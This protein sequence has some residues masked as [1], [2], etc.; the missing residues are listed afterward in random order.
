MAKVMLSLHHSAGAFQLSKNP[1][2][3]GEQFILRFRD[4]EL[5][6]LRTSRSEVAAGQD[7]ADVREYFNY[8]AIFGCSFGEV[9]HYRLEL[10]EQ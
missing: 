4:A 9:R 10:D 6:M 7:G 3:W 1:R 2:Q 8:E 5:P